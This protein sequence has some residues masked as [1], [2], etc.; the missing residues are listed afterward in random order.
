LRS[1]FVDS[2]YLIAVFFPSDR[3][4]AV[5]M[6]AGDD[7]FRPGG[8]RGVTTHLVLAEFLAFFARFPSLIRVRAAD[9][10][11]DMTSTPTFAVI[12][13]TNELF[14]RGLDLYRDRPDKRYSLTDCVS[15]CVCRGMN[16]GEVLTADRDFEAEGFT[17][18][19]ATS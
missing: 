14:Q 8:V 4:H 15:M 7:L 13:V 10:I 18:L 5:A 12:P 16:I 2:S 1:V 11:R 9:S 19:L 3:F 17:I 6:R